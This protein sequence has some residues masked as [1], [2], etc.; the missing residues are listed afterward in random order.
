MIIPYSK[1]LIT[2]LAGKDAGRVNYDTTLGRLADENRRH[3]A[4][5]ALILVR[6]LPVLLTYLYAFL[7]SFILSQFGESGIVPARISCIAFIFFVVVVGFPP[8]VRG[9]SS[10]LVII[11][12]I[13]IAA[14][15]A[16]AT[17]ASS[18]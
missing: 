17:V 13:I 11:T 16:A 14:V 6:Y 15:A 9:I 5:T 2:D 8:L 10:T 1:N 7:F 4:V 3:H 12:A 18:A